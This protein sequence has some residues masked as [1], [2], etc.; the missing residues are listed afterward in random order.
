M[1]VKE[2]EVEQGVP[3]GDIPPLLRPK[4]RLRSGVVHQVKDS[5]L[6][7]M[8]KNWLCRE[9]KGVPGVNLDLNG[10]PRP[11]RSR[12]ALIEEYGLYNNFFYHNLE[13]FNT[14]GST[15]AANRPLAVPQ[16]DLD[17]VFKIIAERRA[18]GNEVSKGEV[19]GLFQLAKNS[20]TLDA[21]SPNYEG[22]SGSNSNSNSNSNH[23]KILSDGTFNRYLKKF[24]VK[25]PVND[26]AYTEARKRATG[27]P[28]MSLAWYVVSDAF[29]GHLPNCNKWNADGTTFVID[30]NGKV[31]FVY[32]LSEDDEKK[33][34]GDSTG[35]LN[36]S[37]VG[38]RSEGMNEFAFAIKIMHFCNA[39]GEVGPLVAIV[40]ISD[41]P[42]GEFHCEEVKT[43]SSSTSVGVSGYIYFTST[44]AGNKNMWVHFFLNILI[45]TILK[46]GMAHDTHSL[47]Y[48]LSTDSEDIIINQAFH[49]EVADSLNVNKI[50]YARIGASLTSIHQACDRQR[51]FVKSKAFVKKFKAA[52]SSDFIEGYGTIRLQFAT[53][54]KNLRSRVDVSD[55]F[56]EKVTNA[57]VLVMEALK[58]S[59]TTDVIQNGFKCC[60]QA[61]STDGS[62]RT[63]SFE[64]IM[65]QCTTSI[66]VEQMRKMKAAAP[67]LIA[68]ARLRGTISYEEIFEQGI[69]PVEGYT[70]DRS[71]MS[72]I[73][74]W[75]E[76]VNHPDIVKKYHEEI[77]SKLPEVV[78]QVKATRV[79]EAKAAADCQKILKTKAAEQAKAEKILEAHNKKVYLDSLTPEDRKKVIKQLAQHNK[80]QKQEKDRIREEKRKAELAWAQSILPDYTAAFQSNVNMATE[81]EG[82]VDEDENDME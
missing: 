1:D 35:N 19:A 77:R 9:V 15:N 61:G 81:E 12:T 82:D 40:A 57:L 34:L 76:I 6:S 29:S 42:V 38:R 65:N 58:A 17:F 7:V 4:H 39:Y 30:A 64:A 2:Y 22:N 79:L 5:N 41:F 37:N 78:E 48:F 21:N 20:R 72:R 74:H 49:P 11:K 56:E 53:A 46:S 62:S 50:A 3:D 55:S 13:T 66:S 32:R 67:V 25:K 16:Q 51:T 80:E 10:Q 24:L 60:G 14:F 54:F 69:L 31:K 26:T 52:S 23:G 71:K 63:V 59:I 28:Y 70:I 44:R 68:C 75:A 27:C 33:Y 18:A 36:Y 43:F 47:G 45:P 73:H 8:E